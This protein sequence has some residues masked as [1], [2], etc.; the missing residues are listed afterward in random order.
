MNFAR[1]SSLA[2]LICVAFVA[3]IG[4]ALAQQPSGT[5]DPGIQQRMEN[6]EN[7]I[8]QGVN[9][10]TLT[11]KETGR[12]EAEQ[13]RIQQA[14]ERMKSDG[15]LTTKERQ[16]LNTM[17]NKAGGDI[18]TQK[19]DSQTAPV[20]PPAAPTVRQRQQ[21][22]QQRVQQGVRSG[23]LT[24]QEAGRLEAEQARIQQSKERMRSDGELT[25]AERQKL[26]TMQDR[27]SRHIYRQK[28]DA[29]SVPGKKKP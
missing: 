23:E 15:N 1:K 8:D 2:A 7:R 6:Q 21:N 5:N 13:A 22:Q 18:Y 27:S 16:R 3:G 26:N 17:Q 12:L 20:T 25:G 4:P 11:P 29:Q 28:H 19:H 14:E 24:P 10:G 9:T